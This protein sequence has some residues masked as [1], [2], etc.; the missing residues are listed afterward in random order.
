MQ[1]QP[2][3]NGPV[4]ALFPLP[5]DLPPLNKQ[6]YMEAESVST[7]TPEE[8]AE[9]RQVC[10]HQHKRDDVVDLFT[11]AASVCAA[12]CVVFKGVSFEPVLFSFPPPH[13]EKRITISLWMT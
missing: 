9:W 4:R 2:F 13:K 11:R 10:P 1:T 8:V 6:F 3:V 5:S 12:S 7:L